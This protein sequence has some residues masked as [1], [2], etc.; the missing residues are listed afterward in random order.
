MHIDTYTY[1]YRFD[2]RYI[3][4]N[5]ILCTNKLLCFKKKLSIIWSFWDMRAEATYLWR[6]PPFCRQHK[7][8][9]TRNEINES[10]GKRNAVIL[11]VKLLFL[12]NDYCP[13][14][15]KYCQNIAPGAEYNSIIL[16]LSYDLCC[17]KKKKFLFIIEIFGLVFCKRWF[18]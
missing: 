7:K 2:F 12:Y 4:V 9:T 10:K 18:N 17:T 13:L 5:N 16:K 3:S 8:Q 14:Y 11:G 15:K 6:V 1:T